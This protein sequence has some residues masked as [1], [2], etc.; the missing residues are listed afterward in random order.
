MLVFASDDLDI[1]LSAGVFIYLLTAKQFLIVMQTFFEDMIL[2]KENGKYR[3][4][5]GRKNIIIM[6]HVK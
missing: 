5:R 1:E 3:I 2:W 4:R 6:I